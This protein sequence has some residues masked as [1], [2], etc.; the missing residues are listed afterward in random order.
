MARTYT[1][2]WTV[3]GEPPGGVRVT[4]D[5]PTDW[6]ETLDGMGSPTFTVP[7]T[8]GALVAIAAIRA[9]GASE[10]ERLAWAMKQQFDSDLPSVE[11]HPRGDGR[12]W[13]V[14]RSGGRLHARM[15]LPA[16]HDSIVMATVMAFSPGAP[17]S[18][19]KL[20]RVFDTVRIASR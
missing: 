15:F 17:A 1:M 20:E 18:L 7:G 5:I 10:T 13:A 4:A 14:L 6:K 3:A 2:F 11:R 8:D 19:P 16:P 12:V 9:P